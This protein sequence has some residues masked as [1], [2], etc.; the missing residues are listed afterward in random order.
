M[1]NNG[2][3]IIFSAVRGLP[4]SCIKYLPVAIFKTSAGAYSLRKSIEQFGIWI[5]FLRHHIHELQAVENGRIFMTKI[6]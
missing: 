3:I 5:T 2:W 4:D 1:V 6:N